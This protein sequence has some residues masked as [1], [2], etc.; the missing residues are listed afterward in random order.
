MRQS[1]LLQF[2]SDAFKVEPGED[3]STSPEVFGKS[4]AIWLASKLEQQGLK[5]DNPIAEDLGWFIEVTIK[6]YKLSIVC[7]NVDGAQDKWQVLAFMEDWL[8]GPRFDR[9][10]R[11]ETLQALFVLIEKILQQA[12]ILSDLRALN[13]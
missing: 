9:N 6:P 11:S 8:T 10:N 2:T 12:T 3:D 7:A 13:D 1:P 4:L 5:V